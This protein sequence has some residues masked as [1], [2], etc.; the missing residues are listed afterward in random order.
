MAGAVELLR[1]RPGRRAPSRRRRRVCP[2]RCAGGRGT[3]QPSP[4]ARSMIDTSICSIVTGSSLISSAHADSHG[5][6]HMRPVNSGKLLVAAGARSRRASARGRRVVPLGD[7]VAERAAAMAEGHA[8]LHAAP[9]LRLH[10]GI[11]KSADHLVIVADALGRVAPGIAGDGASNCQ[12]TARVSHFRHSL[13]A[14][15]RDAYGFGSGRP[16]ELGQPG[17]AASSAAPSCSRAA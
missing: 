13:S 1:R 14:A 12:K 8:A 7:E 10:L 16:G 9:R 17:R 5:A 2:V 4:K 6:G 15:R 11:G 3:T